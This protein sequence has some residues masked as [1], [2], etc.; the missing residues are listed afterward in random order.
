MPAAQRLYVPVTIVC[1][2]DGP[3]SGVGENC[4]NPIKFGKNNFSADVHEFTTL[5]ESNYRASIAFWLVPLPVLGDGFYA[6]CSTGRR[7][8]HSWGLLR[9]GRLVLFLLRVSGCWRS[10][11]RCHFSGQAATMPNKTGKWTAVAATSTTRLALSLFPLQRRVF[12][13]RLANAIR[14][15]RACELP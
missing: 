5:A 14:L 8:R 3:H 11:G 13:G 4:D 7:I 12:Q 1:T 15:L 9:L 2:K 10:G 6:F